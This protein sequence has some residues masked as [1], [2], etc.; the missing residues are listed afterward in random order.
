MKNTIKSFLVIILLVIISLI[1]VSCGN[2]E[3]INSIKDEI[4]Q[5]KAQYDNKLNTYQQELSA[6]NS[7]IVSLEEALSELEEENENDKNDYLAQIEALRKELNE[8]NKVISALENELDAFKKDANQMGTEITNSINDISG[9]VGSVEEEILGINDYLSSNKQ[10]VNVNLADQYY[11]VVGDKFQ[12]FYR[13]VIQAQ[14]PYGYYIRVTGDKGHTFNRYYEV[15]FDVSGVYNL[16]IE[17]CDDNGNVLGKD[18]TKLIVNSKTTTSNKKI[19]VIGDSLTSTGQWIARG[20]SRF[21]QSGGNVVTIGTVSSTHS[22]S[23]LGTGTSSVTVNY[24]GRAGWQWSS[25]VNRYDASTKSPFNDGSGLSF[26]SYLSR[27]SLERFDEVYILMTFNGFTST[28]VYD[29]SSAFLQSAKTLVDKIHSEY[30]GV[31]VTLMGLPLTSTF[32]GLG[33]YYDINRTY[34]DN[35]GVQI[36]IH[37]YD[38][39]LE[40]WTKMDGY[41]GWLRY[42]DVKA[43]F[44]SEWN[45]PYETKNVNS[46]NSS[47]KEN[48][49]TSMGMHPTSNGYNQIGDAFYRSLMS[50]WGN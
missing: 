36:R 16:K 15:T 40:E 20:V 46:T 42:I 27:N 17:V 49:G 8:S 30:P 37:E 44:D 32:A 1:L 34:S 19:L 14:D 39:F 6:N 4:A 21:N 22:A 47:V 10:T 5:Y 41:K 12:L 9:R 48:V 28:D 38:N 23:S 29:F 24:E 25:Y 31:R 11:L 26:S 7:K 3:E 50:K 13:S 2:N 43:Q 33:S 35:Y 45:M 18:T